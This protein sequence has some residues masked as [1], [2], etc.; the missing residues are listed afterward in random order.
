MKRRHITLPALQFA[1]A[2]FF[3]QTAF[4]EKY[5]INKNLQVADMTNCDN[6]NE[7]FSV[8]EGPAGVA[9]GSSVTWN[10]EEFNGA[11][12]MPRTAAPEYDERDLESGGFGRLQDRDPSS[13]TTTTRR[14]GS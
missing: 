8:I 12:A 13:T 1:A 3:A 4:A 6:A 2:A 10:V 9:T 14:S 11:R 5:C 7:G